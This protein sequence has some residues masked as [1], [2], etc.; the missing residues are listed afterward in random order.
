MAVHGAAARDL[1][2][3]FIQRWNF[4]KVLTTEGPE[5]GREKPGSALSPSADSAVPSWQT[6]KAK[7]K[8]PTYP[9]LLPKSTSTA[10]HLPFTIPGGQC[11]TVQ[12]T[13]LISQTLPSLSLARST[14]PLPEN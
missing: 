2:R 10:N 12:V 3:H 14:P 5:G 8:I 1:A 4:T 13:I 11:T 6:T 9:Y 7:Y